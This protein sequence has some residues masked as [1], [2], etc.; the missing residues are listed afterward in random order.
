MFVPT[1][2]SIHSL[3]RQ[4][5][6]SK[7]KM[8]KQQ[9]QGAFCLLSLLCA[10]LQH[11]ILGPGDWVSYCWEAPLVLQAGG[12][13]SS[14]NFLSLCRRYCHNAHRH[15]TVEASQPGFQ[16]TILH[17]VWI[18]GSFLKTWNRRLYEMV[19]FSTEKTDSLSSYI[20]IS[21]R[22]SLG[23]SFWMQDW[24]LAPVLTDNC[25]NWAL[26]PRLR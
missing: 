1:T 7:C 17:Q 13:S 9:R 14:R 4:H 23:E 12:T 22:G 15:S 26:S 8:Y 5:S 21:M 11:I 18:Q 2:A 16:G 20:L 6:S 3:L 10:G 24:D 19:L 25:M